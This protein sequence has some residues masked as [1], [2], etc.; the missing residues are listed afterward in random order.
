MVIIVVTL[1]KREWRGS[2][3]FDLGGEEGAVAEKMTGGR[4]PD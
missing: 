3:G 4:R 1:E 2:L